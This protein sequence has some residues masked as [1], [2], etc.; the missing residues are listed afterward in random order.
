M[1]PIVWCNTGQYRFLLST[2]MRAWNGRRTF[3]WVSFLLMSNRLKK[4]QWPSTMAS[5]AMSITRPT[6]LHSC[7]NV[8]S[9]S[10]GNPAHPINVFQR[11]TCKGLAHSVRSTT[12]WRLTWYQVGPDCRRHECWSLCPG[13]CKSHFMKWLHCWWLRVKLV[14]VDM[15]WW[16][17][18]GLLSRPRLRQ[19][20]TH[21][22]N[23]ERQ[24]CQ[25]HMTC[26]ALCDLL[27]S[28]A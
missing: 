10:Q 21:W 20:H 9:S 22:T 19:G 18:C 8:P 3:D 5:W 2:S 25:G 27:C 7:R 17:L 14:N 28:E 15:H 16:R 24:P 11:N 13:Y 12:G 1:Y 4:G 26:K 6:I 23:T